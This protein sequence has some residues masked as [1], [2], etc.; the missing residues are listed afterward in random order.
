M[1]ACG[2]P[3]KL[4]ACSLRATLPPSGLLWV[5]VACHFGLLGFPGRLLD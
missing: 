4:V 1:R 2:T 5:A 3:G